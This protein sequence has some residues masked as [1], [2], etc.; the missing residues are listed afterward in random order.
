[1]Q[2]LKTKAKADVARNSKQAH[3]ADVKGMPGRKDIDATLMRAIKKSRDKAALQTLA[4]HYGPRLKSFLI[5]RG[6]QSPTAEDIV[7]DAII[8]VWIKADKFDPDKGSFSTWVYRITRN[9]WIDHKRKHGRMQ[10]VEPSIIGTMQDDTIEAADVDFD[11][12]EAAEAVRKEMALLPTEQKQILHLAFF[13]GLSHSQIAN[14]TGLA[15]G[16]VKSRIRI[17]LKKMQGGL[18]D[19]HEL[20][21]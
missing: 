3:E 9:K 15:L 16:T 13:E 1:M 7:Q 6:E 5:H 18:R 21:R 17:S 12:R 14:R 2:A 10:M 8:Q 20:D 11:R 19:H 4:T